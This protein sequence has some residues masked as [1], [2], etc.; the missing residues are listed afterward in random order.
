MLIYSE[1]LLEKKNKKFIR[2]GFLYI[3]TIYIY[4]YTKKKTY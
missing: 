3:Y 2:T 1:Q 4:A